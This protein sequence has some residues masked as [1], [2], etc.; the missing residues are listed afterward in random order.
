MSK[1][2]LIDGLSYGNGI[3][4]S[5][6]TWLSDCVLQGEP[7]SESHESLLEELRE[8]FVRGTS[9]EIEAVVRNLQSHG[10]EIGFDKL[11]NCVAISHPA[12]GFTINNLTTLA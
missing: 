2:E 4:S 9:Q 3:L 10:F 11:R 6:R 5:A 8:L 1:H 7:V 12:K